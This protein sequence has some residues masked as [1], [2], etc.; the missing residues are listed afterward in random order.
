MDR[1]RGSAGEFA[2]F[3]PTVRP[4]PGTD[5]GFVDQVDAEESRVRGVAL[6]E[7]PDHVVDDS[8]PGSRIADKILD[9]TG[10][11]R[12]AAPLVTEIEVE[13]YQLKRQASVV[14]A[15]H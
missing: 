12:N 10:S 6:G 8:L 4:V 3:A 2:H 11:G 9:G 15:V 14:G 1:G 7:R 5:I 13:E